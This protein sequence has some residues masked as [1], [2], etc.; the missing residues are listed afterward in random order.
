LLIKRDLLL[1]KTFMPVYV[2]DT[3]GQDSTPLLQLTSN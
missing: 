2:L 1:R 3:A